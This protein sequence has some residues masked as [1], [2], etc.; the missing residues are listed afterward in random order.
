MWGLCNR[1]M[2]FLARWLSRPLKLALVSVHL[3]SCMLPVFSFDGFELILVILHGDTG[4]CHGLSSTRH[5]PSIFALLHLSFTARGLLGII[6]FYI[7][8]VSLFCSCI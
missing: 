8:C 6:L 2:N 1:P 7:L 5:S 4:V 3:L